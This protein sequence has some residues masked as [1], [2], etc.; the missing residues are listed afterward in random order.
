MPTEPEATRIERLIAELR[1]RRIGY[2][3]MLAPYL[4]ENDLGKAQGWDKLIAKLT[5]ADAETKARAL[6]VLERLHVGLVVAGTKDLFVFELSDS[7]IEQLGNEVVGVVPPA[8]RY[9]DFFPFMADATT[10]AAMDRNHVLIDRHVHDNGDVSFILGA[11]RTYEEREV[12]ELS[13]VTAAVRDAFVGFD[14][15]IAVRRTDYQVFDVLTIRPNLR[16]LEVLIDD[17]DRAHSTETTDTRCQTVLGR[18]AAS[19]PTLAPIY[20][21]DTPIDLA[22][23]IGAMYNNARE[24]RVVR[25]SF[26]SPSGSVNKGLVPTQTD[27]RTDEFHEHGVHGVGTITPYDITVAWD[28]LEARSGTVQVQISMPLSGLSGEG[29]RVRKARISDARTDSQLVSLVN[30]LVSYSSG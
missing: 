5:D 6:T 7:D 8:S 13:E 27:L 23:C 11:K 19:L 4:V 18:M 14:E 20:E 2:R 1:R 3:E 28:Q 10:L 15:F 17:P 9:R 30:K 26:R 16:R 29:H 22:P 24:G 21:T 25:L 12:Y